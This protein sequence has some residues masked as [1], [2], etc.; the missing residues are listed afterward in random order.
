GRLPILSLSCYAYPRHLHSFPTRRSS[1][2]DEKGQTIFWSG[3]VEDNG[4]G[5]VDP[6]AHF[7]R[8][9]QID[10]HGHV[11]NK[12]NAWATRSVVYVHLDRKSTR[13]NSSHSQISYAVFCLQKKN[14]NRHLRLK[15]AQQ[16]Q[17]LQRLDQRRA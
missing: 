6:G 10:A 12:R 17:P 3:E 1:D 5:P 4:K 9:L 11:I 2:L 16:P 14:N 13:L 15:R 7:Y 8:S